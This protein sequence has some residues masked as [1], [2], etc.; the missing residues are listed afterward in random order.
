MR[1]KCINAT[2]PSTYAVIFD[3]G[4]ELIT[5]LTR[6]A[7]EKV[8]SGSQINAVG[9]FSHA[10]IGF[11]DRDRKDYKKIE[12]DE[13]VEVLCLFGDITIEGGTPKVHAHAIIGRA[14]G[15]TRGGHL[16]KALVWPTLEVIVTE[17]PG[18][19]VRRHDPDTGLA[20][21]DPEAE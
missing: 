7:I 19:L 18:Y 4:D 16:I 15:T 9:G 11:F 8:L 21:I 1:S 6:F 13:Q 3:K 10:T 2:N 17:S 20:L 14:D 12:L 5:G